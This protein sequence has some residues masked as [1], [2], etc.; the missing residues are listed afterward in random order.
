MNDPDP[1][2]PKEMPPY[3]DVNL[4]I[5]INFAHLPSLFLYH[6]LDHEAARKEDS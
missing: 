1:G 2:H 4:I 6:F 3:L 5:A